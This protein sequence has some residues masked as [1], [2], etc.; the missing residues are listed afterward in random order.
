MSVETD[1]FKVAL[2]EISPVEAKDEYIAKIEE[3]SGLTIIC[4]IASDHLD[5]CRAS[6]LGTL[7]TPDTKDGLTKD[8]LTR[9]AQKVINA[10]VAHR[11]IL[12]NLQDLG[13]KVAAGIVKAEEEIGINPDDPTFLVGDRAYE[14]F[15]GRLTVTAE[16]SGFGEHI[17]HRRVFVASD[18]ENLRNLFEGKKLDD[19][20]K[21]NIG[22]ARIQDWQN[23]AEDL[24]SGLTY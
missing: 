20:K 4:R 6:Y 19:K 23:L 21:E 22:L 5:C 9:K 16:N 8:V 11:Q 7:S 17:N 1:H 12:D 14:I 3:L 18:N 24:L 13:G 15:N 2:N 10:R